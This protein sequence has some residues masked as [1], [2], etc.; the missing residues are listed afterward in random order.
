MAQ[1]VHP[2][3]PPGQVLEVLQRGYRLGERLLRPARVVVAKAPEEPAAE[4]PGAQ[5]AG[6]AP[7]GEEQS[8]GEDG[9]DGGGPAVGR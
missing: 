8:A 9:K 2:E 6:K 3:A 1:A 5:S 4:A 7:A